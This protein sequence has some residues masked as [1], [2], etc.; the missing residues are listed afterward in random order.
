MAS[1]VRERLAQH[2]DKVVSD[3]V[4]RPGVNGS[5]EA[6]HRLEAECSGRLF[7]QRQHL[8]THAAARETGGV[9][10]E[11]GG[12]DLAHRGVEVVHGLLESFVQ[13]WAI[14]GQPGGIPMPP[15]KVAVGV[16][17][18]VMRRRPD[19]RAAELR[20]MA[21]CDRIGIVLDRLRRPHDA[22]IAYQRA[23]EAQRR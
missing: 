2:G 11:D 19:I 9:Q 10:L 13:L 8:V 16:P 1:D 12:T 3:I 6:H 18:D 14:L 23:R 4:V 21:Q 22:A 7:A 17:A 20:A 15:A 5:V